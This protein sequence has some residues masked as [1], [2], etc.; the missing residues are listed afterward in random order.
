MLRRDFIL[1]RLKFSVLT[2]M[3]F[4]ILIA[5]DSDNVESILWPSARNAHAS[6]FNP[7][8]NEMLVFGGSLED[9]DDNSLWS[10]KDGRWAA[11]S[12]TGPSKREDAL[13]VYHTQNQKAYLIGGRS[14]SPSTTF[15]DFWE[16]D[17]TTWKQLNNLPFG[18]LT[19]A[20]ATYDEKNNRILVFGGMAGSTLSADL[21]MWDG[22]NWSKS[23][24]TG[25]SAR[26]AAS[27]LYSPA[28]QKV[29]LF[30]GALNDGTVIKEVWE[31]DGEIW[32]KKNET[33]PSLLTN[34]YGVAPYGN[35][36]ML[37]GGFKENRQQGEETWIYNTSENTWTSAIISPPTPRALH[38]MVYDL[39]NAR[40]IMFGGSAAGTLLD[41]LWIYASGVWS[42]ETK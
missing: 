17:G 29:F 12:S 6:V 24:A 41:E 25:P 35:N 40:I 10:F 27:L 8:Q 39:Q 3:L 34:A 15:Q 11:L 16:W 28:H 20:S 31:L 42:Q 7:L 38:S 9:G 1:S 23:S 18:N 5:C 14:F 30:G 37:F 36:F 4:Q 2:I 32:T 33:H 26:L 13:L 19:H 22:H 21:W